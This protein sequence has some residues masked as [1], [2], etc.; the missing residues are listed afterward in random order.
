MF[1]EGA[2]SMHRSW[3]LP[4]AEG[5]SFD[6]IEDFPENVRETAAITQLVERWL[7][8]ECFVRETDDRFVDA[9]RGFVVFDQAFGL[10]HAFGVSCSRCSSFRF[11]AVLRLWF[12]RPLHVKSLSRVES[13]PEVLDTVKR[14]QVAIMPASR[15][16]PMG[17]PR[18][19]R[20]ED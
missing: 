18:R 20:H 16:T 4:L 6:T 2:I 19:T 10:L 9:L 7:H 13:L 11:R 1:R 14:E 3:T 12:Q 5:Q 8:I 15:R 17:F